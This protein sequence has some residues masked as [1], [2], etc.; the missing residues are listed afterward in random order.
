[1][2]TD[3]SL[4]LTNPTFI[5]L[6]L[7]S[8]Y[9][10]TVMINQAYYFFSSREKS[11][12]L[13]QLLKNTRNGYHDIISFIKAK[14]T[15]HR[16]LIRAGIDHGEQPAEALGALLTEEAKGLRWEAE[17]SEFYGMEILPERINCVIDQPEGIKAILQHIGLW[18][19]QKRPPSEN[20]TPPSEY[21]AADQIPVYDSVD[22]DYPFE[23]YL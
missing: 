2:Y 3:L 17:Q 20:K 15:P 12:E 16:R 11:P 5:I 4:Y 14:N 23:A 18:V 9:S 21:Y 13:L 6:A 10:V 19:T 8:L 7:M 22:P 1:M